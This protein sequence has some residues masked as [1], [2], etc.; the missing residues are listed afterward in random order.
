MKLGCTVTSERGKAVTK[1]GNDF[2]EVS[3][4]DKFENKV[5]TIRIANTVGELPLSSITINGN[6]NILD[7]LSAKIQRKTN[8]NLKHGKCNHDWDNYGKCTIC[9]KWDTD[10]TRE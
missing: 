1:T 10:G 5:L 3:I 7:A 4:T 2:I 9:G 8:E 6:Q